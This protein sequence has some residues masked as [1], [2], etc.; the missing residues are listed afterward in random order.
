MFE[1]SVNNKIF[2]NWKTAQLSRTMDENAGKFQF[3]SSNVVPANYPVRAGD[4]VKILISGQSKLMG[5]CE[6]VSSN[7]EDGVDT[8]T[9]AGRDNICDIIDSTMPD[10]VKNIDGPISLKA[11]IEKVIDALGAN[12]KVISNVS[13]IADFA[14]EST[15]LD[16][17]EDFFL[18]ADAGKNCME[19]LTDFARKRQVYLVSDG[20]GKIS[21][22]RPSST[23]T[24]GVLINK[25]D[26]NKNNILSSALNIDISQRFGTYSSR[27]QSN[28]GA[29]ADADYDAGV[30]ISGQSIDSQIRTSRFLE[31]QGEE[32]FN[33]TEVKDRAIEELNIRKAR[34]TSYT[35]VVVGAERSPGALWDIGQLTKVD[36]DYSDIKGIFLTRSVEYTTDRESGTKTR[37]VLAPPEA[38]NV[39]VPTQGD[40]RRAKEGT[41]FQIETPGVSSGRFI[42]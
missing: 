19:Y 6:R 41:S 24:P 12:I 36:D 35:A 4:E 14:L 33:E 9:V 42:R 32:S 25:K 23:I 31:L 16:S 3:S 17:V 20:T 34:S 10:T 21:I 27:S 40:K 38:Y 18:G 2:S 30:D 22:F 5:F 15:V 11:L 28:F 39:R 1:I 29:D 7:V 13:D 37:I 26:N 8:I